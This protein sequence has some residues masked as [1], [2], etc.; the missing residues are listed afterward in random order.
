MINIGLVGC[1]TI[2][3]ELA[4][5]IQKKLNAK[6][7][8]VA[9]CDVDEDKTS[10]LCQKLE[11][12]HPCGCCTNRLPEVMV[13]DKL[14]SKVDLV[15]ETAVKQAAVELARKTVESGRDIMIMSVGAM[16]GQQSLFES[17]R[18][19]G[20]KIYLPS[21]AI[22]G[23][24]GVKS[25]SIGNITK[26]VL[27]T[28]KP[29]KGLAGAPY[30]IEN[31]IDLEAID[32]DTVIFEGSAL[33]AVTGFPKNVNV[34]AALSLAGIG[35][36]KTRVLII[37]SPGAVTNSHQIEVEGQFGKLT[38]R[39]ENVP[40]PNNPKTSYLAVLSAMATLNQIVDSV[41][42]GT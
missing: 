30:I 1:G 32:R 25:A 13:F 35:P 38:S 33:D 24:D 21:G 11:P 40:S 28:T 12:A 39:T 4:V 8:L 42:V 27:T 23:L 22:C 26:V 15:I 20:V 2:G 3:S 37:A 41:K 34:S 31:K 36:E 5:Y 18:Q 9:V 6:A 19:K 14:I 10:S 7:C 17:A 16:L 29:P